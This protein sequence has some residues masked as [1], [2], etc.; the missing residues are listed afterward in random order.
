[1]P[2]QPTDHQPGDPADAPGMAETSGALGRGD[3]DP[4]LDG[5]L[6][7][8]LWD[9]ADPAGSEAR[10]REAIAAAPAGALA[11]AELRTQ[12]ARA[13]GLQ[14]RY[15][16]ATAVLDDVAAELG[17]VSA[18]D[19]G[20]RPTLGA[21]VALERGRVRNSSGAPADA[22][23]LF[24]EAL[25]LSLI[26]HD[27]FLAADAAHM[28]AIADGEH[29]DQWTRRGLEIA[30]SSADPRT[31]RW[32]GSL[33]NNLGWSLHGA[34]RFGEALD[35]FRSALDAYRTAGTAEQIRIARWAVARCLRS[36]ERYEEALVIQ[37][38][39]AAGP[40]DGYVDEELGE[41]LLALGRA[42]EARPHFAVA[43]DKLGADDWLV[44]HEP[45]RI[46]RLRELSGTGPS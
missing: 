19:P 33:H 17:E 28:L 27:D 1:M 42:D 10:F 22:V 21:R 8:R 2:D 13:L 11:T 25:D 43:A 18:A 26:A 12:L 6:L 44:E 37:T 23:P 46:A 7:D 31:A 5:K 39:L 38:E 9:F 3:A 20:T 34:G 45:A 36:L 4:A 30:Q 32:A 16:Q 24:R 15:E 41:L 29:S 14:G 35:E 40:S